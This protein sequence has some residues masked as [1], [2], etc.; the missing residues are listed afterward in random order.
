MLALYIMTVSDDANIV[1]TN[2]GC[3]LSVSAC[4]KPLFPQCIQ[5]FHSDIYIQES[6]LIQFFLNC[7]A[8]WTQIVGVLPI[9]NAELKQGPLNV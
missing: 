3:L 1:K 4:R 5:T 6:H 2:P 7:G 8:F 9:K